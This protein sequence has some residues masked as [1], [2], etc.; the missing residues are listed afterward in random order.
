MSRRT[1][2]VSIFLSCLSVF[3]VVHAAPQIRTLVLTGHPGE[4]PVV[5]MGGHSYVEIEALTRLANGSLSFSGTQIVVTLPS[6]G[7]STTAKNPEAGDSATL[8]FSKNFLQ[9][10]I[11]EMA[12]I[13]EWRSTLVHAVRQEMPVTETWVAS[14]YAEAQKN[15]R[16]VSLAV[17]TEADRNAFQL[18]TNELSNMKKLSDR[19]AE[20]NKSRTYVGTDALEND[21]L[22]KRIL[23]CAHSL[24]AMAANNQ[25]IDDG[26]CH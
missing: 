6:P 22:D 10:A 23:N 3:A 19:F 4:L 1:F 25:F 21:P 18:L 20:A 13:R 7:P 5:E 14:S 9:A 26:S 12:V 17:V 8:G 24:A 11:E 2:F 15:L 16:L